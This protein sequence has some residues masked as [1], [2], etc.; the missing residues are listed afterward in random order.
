V[1]PLPVKITISGSAIASGGS[2][3]P[4]TATAL[5]EAIQKAATAGLVALQAD[6]AKTLLALSSEQLAKI[7]NTGKPLAVTVQGVQFILSPDSLKVPE[8]TAANAAQLQLSA[9]KL[10]AEDVQSLAEPLTGKFKL[11]GDIY[12]LS[13]F[14]VDKDGKQQSVKQF[15]DCRVL[16]PVP[17][18]AREAAAAGR[19]KACRYNE[20]SKMWE[21]VGG[22]YDVAGGVIRFKADHFSKYALLE[23]LSPPAIKSF[24]DIAGHW[25]QKEIEFMA[26]KG[27]VA[28]VGDNRFAPD[29]TITRAEFAVIL[30][31]MAGLTDNPGG[32][33]RFSDVPDGAW[34]RGMV[35]AAADAGLVHG[36]GENSFAPDEPITREQ[37][38]A[39][40]AR[41]LAGNSPDTAV[42]DAAADELLAGF[43]DAASVSS[44]ARAAVALT[45][46]EKLMVG[47]ESGRFAPLGNTT[48]AEAAVVLYR[49]LQKLPQLGE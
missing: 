43:G 39:M 31:R 17:E 18:A 44:W 38:A 48:R 42:S 34:Y 26:A 40:M 3:A 8:L 7:S 14:V 20:E 16:L 2:A 37:M 1:R 47:R 36:T 29:L 24:K 4:V 35:G 23:T 13:I 12:D 11:A 41:L 21:E 32:A 33:D 27:Y 28:G 25:A 9:R 10:S 46:R 5:E 15:P 6:S 45:V 49:L 19:V 30:A 22:A